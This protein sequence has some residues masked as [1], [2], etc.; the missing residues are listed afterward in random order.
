MELAI[1]LF[2]VNCRLIDLRVCCVRWYS[3]QL[4]TINVI[5]FLRPGL[6]QQPSGSRSSILL[7]ERRNPPDFAILPGALNERLDHGEI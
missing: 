7:T 5:V 6:Q 1:T 3:N 2:Q 4:V